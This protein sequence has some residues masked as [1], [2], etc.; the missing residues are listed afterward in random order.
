[1]MD[2]THVSDT[3]PGKDEDK[4]KKER[5]ELT[6]K[7][8]MEK[9]VIEP[10]TTEAKL[11]EMK[12]LEARRAEQVDIKNIDIA[13]DVYDDIFSDFD[14]S[15]YSRRMISEDFVIE[16]MKR[17]ST[18]MAV[19]PLH[20]VFSIPLSKRV[21]TVEKAIQKRIKQ[22]F[23]R[24]IADMDYEIK[25]YQQRGIKYLLLGLAILMILLLLPAGQLFTNA[26]VS[27]LEVAG[28]FCI[29]TGLSKIF[30]EPSDILKTKKVYTLLSNAHYVFVNE[31]DIKTD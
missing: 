4:S 20:V 17:A 14:I 5:D 31:E 21:P 11:A 15:P 1:M 18:E 25:V 10:E 3:N 19:G 30:D 2:K 13:L 23:S 22:H 9:G 24:K 27:V 16:L 8:E 7:S 28:W 29:W 12:S 26:M 6:E